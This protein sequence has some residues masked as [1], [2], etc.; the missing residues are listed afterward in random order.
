M[1]VITYGHVWYKQEF[2]NQ[3]LVYSSHARF[4][5]LL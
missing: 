4:N 2:R 5:F 1:R 3:D